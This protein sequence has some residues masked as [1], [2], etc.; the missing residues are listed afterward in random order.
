[1]TSVPPGRSRS[2]AV[3][4]RRLLAATIEHDVES[5]GF[6]LEDGVHDVFAPR[7]ADPG[8]SGGAGGGTAVVDVVGGEYRA[9][10]GVDCREVHCASDRT[11]AEDANLCT[12]RESSLSHR[13]DRDRQRLRYGRFRRR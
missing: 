10:A 2:T 12:G 11:E 5:Q 9:A 6:V 3:V 4:E 1:M 13:V 8:D 7:V